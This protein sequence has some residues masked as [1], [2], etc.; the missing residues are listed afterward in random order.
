MRS[1]SDVI[2]LK[3]FQIGRRRLDSESFQSRAA[4]M[5]RLERLGERVI[6]DHRPPR[7]VYEV[8]AALH[9]FELLSS[10]EPARLI[11]HACVQGHD[12][13]LAQEPFERDLYGPVAQV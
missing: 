1:Q 2:E 10:D 3:Q 5:P 8:S 11:R 7:R 4:Q 9:L 13:A 12:V 6:I